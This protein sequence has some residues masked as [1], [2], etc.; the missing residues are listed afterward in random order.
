MEKLKS[1]IKLW[2]SKLKE[3][4]I[5]IVISCGVWTIL[6][7]L[8]ER[9]VRGFLFGVLNFFTG[10]LLS[11]DGQN[12]LGG[13]IGRTLILMVFNTFLSSLLIHKGPLKTRFAFAKADFKKGLQNLS[14]Y[15]SSFSLFATKDKEI[16]FVG[17][18]GLGLSII[19]NAFISGNGAIVN[20]FS[21]IALFILLLEQFETKSGFFVAVVNL[22][23]RKLGYKNICGDKV[24]AFI[25]AF[26]A[27]CLL[28]PVLAFFHLSDA[29]YVIGILM[30]IA[31]VVGL[32]WTKGLLKKFTAMFLLFLLLL[33]NTQVKAGGLEVPM[34]LKQGTFTKDLMDGSG[35]VFTTTVSDVIVNGEARSDEEIELYPGD[36]CSFT[37]ETDDCTLFYMGLKEIC[38]ICGVT[39]RYENV[40]Q[41]EEALFATSRQTNFY[42]KYVFENIKISEEVFSG[43]LSGSFRTDYIEVK[44]EAGFYGLCSSCE[45]ER[46]NQINGDG[47]FVSN[48]MT[49]I[50]TLEIEFSGLE[51]TSQKAA[52]NNGEMLRYLYVDNE[53]SDLVMDITRQGDVDK[54]H[55][56]DDDKYYFEIALDGVMCQIFQGEDVDY[57]YPSMDENVSNNGTPD[58]GADKYPDYGMSEEEYAEMLER[59][60]SVPLNTTVAVVAT[61]AAAGAAATVAA[62]LTS[63]VESA[64]GMKKK[65]GQL[66]V[67]GDVDIPTV[68]YSDYEKLMI[69]VNIADGEE[70]V[71]AITAIAITPDD[72]KLVKAIAVPTSSSS[73]EIK[74]EI[75]RAPK[76]TVTTYI[77]VTALGVELTGEHYF[78]ETMVEVNIEP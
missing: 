73:A 35:K 75:Q 58:Y 60:E 42:G 49:G 68:H 25:E 16:I 26:M 63:V 18:A 56:E 57:Y 45:E 10:A 24:L 21:C 20:T 33:P 31:G 22:G 29:A 37:V 3:M 43:Q 54:V 23:A 8:W 51:L 17:V 67:N 72:E 65:K 11:V 77:E 2:I 47:S 53:R 1:G 27:G 52:I 64:A 59:G 61:V 55:I 14:E 50:S 62:P 32:L 70:V 69:P 6:V 76:E 9:G 36:V 7:Y 28:M 71:W 40:V 30:T 19:W 74:L 15:V 5:S 13:V 44:D 12:M 38:T 34:V 78:H 4:W 66:V 41:L 48:N 46:Y 39:N